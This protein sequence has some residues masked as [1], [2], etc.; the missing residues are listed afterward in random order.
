MPDFNSLIARSQEHQVPIFEL[1]PEQL[2]Q[3]GSV[4]ASSQ[5]SQDQFRQ[6]FNDAAKR[7]I[8]VVDA[9]RP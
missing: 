9:I 6:L 8:K 5:K 2:E 3:A 7:T 4:L 1:T